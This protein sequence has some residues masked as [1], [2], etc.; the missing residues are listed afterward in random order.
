M[1]VCAQCQFENPLDHKFCQKCGASLT[2]KP[3]FQ[4]EQ[5]VA[6]GALRCP[7]CGAMTG[8][9]WWAIAE[10]TGTEP[11]AEWAQW[12]AA[13]TAPEAPPLYVDE[14]QRYHILAGPLSKDPTMLEFRV[15]DQRPL[16]LSPLDMVAAEVMFKLAQGLESAE[17]L[18]P[19]LPAIA[20]PYLGLQEEGNLAV[21]MLQDAWQSPDQT[22]LI[23]EDRSQWPRVAEQWQEEQA[24]PLQMLSWLHEMTHLWSALEPWQAQQSLLD[25]ENLCLDEDQLLCLRRLILTE[26]SEA[27]PLAILG[28]AWRSLLSLSQRTQPGELGLLIEDMVAGEVLTVEGVQ[29]RL[30]AI[31]QSLQVL[32][33][34]APCAED[35]GLP[36][37]LQPAIAADWTVDDDDDD[38]ATRP[39]LTPVASFPDDSELDFDAG[40]D[41]F[42]EMPTVVLPMRLVGLEESGRTDIGQHRQHNEDYFGM[43]SQI[44]KIESPSGQTV[45]AQG[46]YILCDGMGGHAGGEVASALVV[47]VLRQYFQR[48]WLSLPT[49][50]SEASNRGGGLGEDWR[51]P[52]PDEDSI[53][54]AIHLANQAVYD[55]NQANNCS[56]SGRMGT[57]LVLVLVQDNRVAVAHVGDSRL[58]RL[59]RKRGLEQVTL[60]HEVGQQ[61]ILQGVDPEAAYG[62]PDAYQLT[63][64]LGPRDSSYVKP[65]VQFFDLAEDT[66]LLLCSDGLCD[67]SLLEN[68]WV[69]KLEPFLSSR[70]NLDL[71]ISQLVDFANG[72]NGHDNITAVAI[73]LKVRP[74]LEAMQRT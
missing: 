66:I 55:I 52:L 59:S 12:Q 62:R 63:Q 69:S 15:H 49:Q 9:L 37:E 8:T 6:L 27:L 73:R 35:L 60:D 5:P 72:Y 3:C 65:D 45:R 4:C 42:D 36:P 10:A 41:S 57:T 16:E 7:N 61:A 1:L 20:Y 19:R 74:N 40:D 44:Y 58:Y 11:P 24:S 67:N 26:G 70:T 30:A 34:T 31:A 33:E 56:G 21:P 43:Q 38:E 28:E 17:T 46:L 50:A 22:V 64:A 53:R 32:P 68:H 48:E 29:E 54:Q 25:S 14:Q 39:L 23:L 13:L 47:E 2:E 18:D 51:R 71:G